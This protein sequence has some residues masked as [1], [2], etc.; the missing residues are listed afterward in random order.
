MISN[1]EDDEVNHIRARLSR[2][3]KKQEPIDDYFSRLAVDPRAH[4]KVHFYTLL[5]TVFS[6]QFARVISRKAFVHYVHRHLQCQRSGRLYC[7][8]VGTSFDE[9]RLQSQEPTGCAA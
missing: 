5:A 3:L 9:V 8:E 2:V 6:I 4:G 7:F 1:D